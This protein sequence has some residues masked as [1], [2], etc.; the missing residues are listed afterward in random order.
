MT[1]CPNLILSRSYRYTRGCSR[2]I[3]S[4]LFC[5]TLS[6]EP[7]QY[8]D[9][10]PLQFFVVIKKRTRVGEIWENLIFIS[11]ALGFGQL[12]V[13]YI[14]IKT[15]AHTQNI[16]TISIYEVVISVYLFGCPI[17]TQKPQDQFASN[18]IGELGRTTRMFLTWL[19]FYF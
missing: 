4:K 19:K 6:T 2:L 18:C 10:R 3:A 11:F 14:N 15:C 8:L 12:K 13:T 16:N 9:C 7:V 1:F 17:I 5:C